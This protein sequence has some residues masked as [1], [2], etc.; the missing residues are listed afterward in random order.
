M[1]LTAIGSAMIF[2]SD[3]SSGGTDIAALILKK[4]TDIEILKSEN[5]S[6]G[7]HV[8]LDIPPYISGEYVISEKL[9]SSNGF[10]VLDLGEKTA[11]RYYE[12]HNG[13]D[14]MT[15]DRPNHMGLKVASIV[16]VDFGKGQIIAKA[17]ENIS[18]DDDWYSG[19]S[20][21]KVICSDGEVEI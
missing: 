5:P 6:V 10:S 2:N 20:A 21:T 11:I 18:K 12:K 15:T 3:A 13:P 4:F 17:I 9:N 16:N 7:E 8:I 14:L 19:G 1:L